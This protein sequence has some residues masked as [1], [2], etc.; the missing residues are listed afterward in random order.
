MGITVVLSQWQVSYTHV[1]VHV[2]GCVHIQV[3]TVELR[4]SESLL[5]EPLMIRMLFRI[6]KSQ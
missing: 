1:H 3:C 5:S 6:L 4:L 2:A